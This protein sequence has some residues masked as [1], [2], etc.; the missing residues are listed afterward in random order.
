M[1]KRI[2]VPVDGSHTAPSTLRPRARSFQYPGRA[3]GSK[4]QAQGFCIGGALSRLPKPVLI[5]WRRP[6][7][8]AN[9]LMRRRIASIND[10]PHIASMQGSQKDSGHQ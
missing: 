7:P 6:W 2:L 8:S 10:L 4:L 1:D 9:G 3:R 5:T